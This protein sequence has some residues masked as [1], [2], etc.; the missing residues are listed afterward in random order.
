[1]SGE[2][3]SATVAI[4]DTIEQHKAG[5]LK[6]PAMALCD[7]DGVYGAARFYTKGNEHGVQPIVGAELTLDDGAVL[8]V[9]VESQAGYQ[10]LLVPR[11]ELVHHESVTRGHPRATVESSRRHDREITLFRRRWPEFIA[12]DPCVSPHLEPR[13][14]DLRIVA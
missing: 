13:N 5:K 8:P 1:M 3:D 4:P 7:R 6:I 11:A 10:N 9:L 2:V 14:G 12:C